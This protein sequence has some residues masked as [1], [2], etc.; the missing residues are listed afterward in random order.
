MICDK[1]FT[2]ILTYTIIMQIICTYNEQYLTN[3]IIKEYN[4]IHDRVKSLAENLKLPEG[5]NIKTVIKA[6]NN[7]VR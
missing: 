6:K 1:V 7:C 2:C 5:L 4:M 3:H